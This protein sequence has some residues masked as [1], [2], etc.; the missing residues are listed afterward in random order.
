MGPQLGITERDLIALVNRRPSS[1]IAQRVPGPGPVDLWVAKVTHDGPLGLRAARALLGPQ[2]SSGRR[3]I[4][5]RRRSL[6]AKATLARLA[7]AR[8]HVDPAA[9]AVAH[10]ERGRPVLLD[11][12]TL[13]ASIAH[14]G[15][16]V[17]CALSDRRV[18]VDIERVDR[19]EADDDLAA[20]VCTLAER[21]QLEHIPAGSRRRALIRLWARKE[22]LAKALGLGVAVPFDQLDVRHHV[23]LIGGARAGALRVRDLE[24]GPEGYV[25]AVA[26]EGRGYRVRA[27]LVVD[28]SAW[29][30]TTRPL[31]ARGPSRAAAHSAG[32]DRNRR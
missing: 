26:T 27:H 6:V 8:M 3:R 20:H 30:M 2:P 25:V 16:F 22:A 18:G 4:D 11:S 10:D 21:R 19:P 24:G 28:D 5:D 17:A 12:P 1:R 9:V 15:E 13:H 31:R 14:S 7:A 32:I 29:R 23:P